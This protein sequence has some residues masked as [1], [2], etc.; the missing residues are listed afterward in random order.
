MC[1]IY[2]ITA[3]DP[4]FIQNFIRKCEHRGPDGHKVW[5]DP[6]HQ[7]TLGHNLLSIMAQ[8]QLSIQPWKTPNGNILV[9]NGEIF[10][11]YE[12][13]DKYKGKGFTGITGCDTELLAWGLDEFGLDFL[14]Q[15]DSM[16]GFAYYEP[17][18]KQITIS[19]DHAGIKPLYYAEIK[20]GLV[21]GSEIKGMLGKV[22]NAH[23]IDQLAM[24]CLAHT[25]INATR[26]TVFNNIKK[27]L[28]G[29][30]LTYS[31]QQKRFVSSKKIRIRPGTKNKFDVEEFRQKSHETVKM[32][33]IGQRQI[34]VF[35]SGGLDSSLVAHELHKIMPP[36]LTF[37]N[38][39]KPNVVADEEDFN[40]DAQ[41]AKILADIEGYKHTEIEITPSKMIDIWDDSIYYMEQPMYNQSVP[42]YCYTNR[43]LHENK[44]VVTMAGDMGDEILGGYPKYWKM[45]RHEFLFKH[46]R[47]PKIKTWED[48]MTLWMNR[49]K[50]PLLLNEIGASIPKEEVKNELL[51]LYTDDLFDQ[52]DPINSYMALDCVTQV[53]EEFFNRND[54]Y[55]MAYG[56]E[57][58]FPLA[59]KMFMKYCLNI[60]SASKI[61]RKK[62]NTKMLTKTAYK[63]ILPAQVLNKPKTGWTVP[64]GYWLTKNMDS[65]I[66]K[67]YQKRLK[68]KS[69]LNIIT[70]SQKTG[71]ALL[72]S[73]IINDWMKTYEIQSNNDI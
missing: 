8:P 4:E 48:V 2:G 72:P 5:W 21:F 9:Y 25:G 6:D 29:E 3:H 10:N 59:T 61:G 44:V 22:D 67:F 36:A 41:V 18:K 47:K 46:L 58:R 28:A 1:G 57:G 65:K 56:M 39:M 27:L 70:A 49:I 69:G 73:W 42:M 30:T 60:P 26:N 31:L 11:Y 52:N 34:G 12:L 40:S 32:C 16:H 54:K 50:R 71:K 53:P 17:K 62:S 45:T 35:L 38:R 66:T 33:S 13:K 51:K 55:G 15:I 63:G 20:E 24:S 43:V 19:R 23:K 7:V 14:D 68:E 64:I 37:T